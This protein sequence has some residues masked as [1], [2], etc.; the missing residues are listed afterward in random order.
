ME[1]HFRRALRVLRMVH[2]LHKQ[3]YQLLR[4]APGM[5][6]SGCSWR[7]SIA[8]R[9]NILKSHGAKL[10]D[11][12]QLAAHYSSSQDN[13]YFGWRDSKEATV[14]ELA[15]R[16]QE[17]FPDIVAASRGDDWNYA[18]WYVRMLGYAERELFPI[19]YADWDVPP[20]PRFL[21]LC[22]CTSDLPMPPPGD[23]DDERNA[24]Q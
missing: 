22:G 1:A 10:K 18:G 24:D 4:I 8:P 14:Q 16:F 12:D 17:R 6:S 23:A 9:S 3:G 19:A 20:N 21:P 2:E 7:C 15:Q 5:S 11:W 13:E